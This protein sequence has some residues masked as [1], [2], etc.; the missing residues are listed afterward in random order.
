M[1]VRIKCELKG[2]YE[3]GTNPY[4]GLVIE[5]PELVDQIF[6]QKEA[7]KKWENVVLGIHNLLWNGKEVKNVFYDMSTNEICLEVSELDWHLCP[8]C[9]LGYEGSPIVS[10]KDNVTE[11]CPKCNEKE[12]LKI[13]KE[14]QGGIA[15]EI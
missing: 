1:K 14:I 9:H 4:R 13:L 12:T 5:V 6:D 2:I 7:S 3:C 8:M 15:N 10:P 11:I